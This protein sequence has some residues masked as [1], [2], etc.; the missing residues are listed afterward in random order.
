MHHVTE[1]FLEF[2]QTLHSQMALSQQ[3]KFPVAFSSISLNFQ[4]S[5]EEIRY[6][7]LSNCKW[8]NGRLKNVSNH[9][10]NLT[11]MKEAV[12]RQVPKS[13]ILLICLACFIP[14]LKAQ[15]YFFYC[16]GVQQLE[17]KLSFQTRATAVK[18]PSNNG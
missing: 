9:I 12:Q 3:R 2:T 7:L 5:C 10:T 13:V 11:T 18:V 16:H 6:P 15:P 4:H 8:K 14:A 17:W 1:V